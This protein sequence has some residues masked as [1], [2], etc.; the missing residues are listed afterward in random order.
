M[1]R[2]CQVIK[3]IEEEQAHISLA[4]I[5]AIFASEK[6]EEFREF[7]KNRATNEKEDGL[8]PD[9]IHEKV[10]DVIDKGTVEKDLDDCLV[11]IAKINKRHD[12]AKKK[13]L[14]NHELGDVVALLIGGIR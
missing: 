10:M 12:T 9:E 13:M 7:L 3:V 2:T 8:V 1:C 11:T 5:A 4:A 6:I 14:M